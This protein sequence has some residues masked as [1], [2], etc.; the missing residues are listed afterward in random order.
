MI[1][2]QSQIK[3]NLASSLKRK[4]KVKAEGYGM[5]LAGYAKFLMVKDIKESEYPVFEPSESTVRAYKRAKSGKDKIIRIN[6]TNEL[7]QVLD[8]LDK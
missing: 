6:S 3:I 1:Q 8:R 5:T 2:K 4:V 7:D